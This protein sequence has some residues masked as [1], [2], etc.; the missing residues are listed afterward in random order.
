[1]PIAR[2]RYG[3]HMVVPLTPDAF[4][5]SAR[6][7]A[8]TAL[9][10]HHARKYRRVAIDAGTAL[11]HLAKACLAKR[12]PGLLAEMKNEDN[13]FHS[14]SLLLGI[15]DGR[16]SPS[17]LRTVGLWSALKRART[18]VTSK[19]TEQDLRTLADMRDGTVH[20]AENAEVEERLVAA[21]VQQAD[22]FLDDLARDRAAF[23]GAHAAV[24]DALLADASDKLAYR[25]GLKIAAASANLEV[26]YG[27]ERPEVLN[28]VAGLARPRASDLTTEL[29]ECPACAYTAVATG[30]HELR[31]DYEPQP[32]DWGPDDVPVGLPAVWFSADGLTCPVC[33]LRLD[34]LAEIEAAGMSSRWELPDEDPE[35][36]MPVHHDEDEQYEAWREG[37][38]LGR[39]E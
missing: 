11:E 27:A 12:S 21:F 23:W 15:A 1:M 28:F 2:C 30:E 35:P 16:T 20:A 25:V 34:S 7:F 10:A 22:E 4:Y 38:R 19:V 32:G 6:E 29:A 3:H 36:Y 33:G 5:D 13:T 8:E 37:L 17:R 31:W 18:F 9:A 14:I 39:D 24:V 26:R